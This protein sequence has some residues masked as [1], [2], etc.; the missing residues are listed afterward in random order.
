MPY[1]P[2]AKELVHCV[3]MPTKASAPSYT[4]LLSPT[5]TLEPELDGDLLFKKKGGECGK[6]QA[7][8]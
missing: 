4:N 8:E 6:V 2:A 5:A 1:H 3:H 7:K